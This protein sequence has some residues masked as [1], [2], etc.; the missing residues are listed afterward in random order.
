MKEAAEQVY[1]GKQ[2]VILN[3][4]TYIVGKPKDIPVHFEKIFYI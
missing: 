1:S 4:H 2:E 3:S